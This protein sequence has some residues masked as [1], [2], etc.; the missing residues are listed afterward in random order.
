MTLPNAPD[1]VLTLTLSLAVQAM[2]FVFAASA[3]ALMLA[4][5][6]IVWGVRLA[7]YLLFRISG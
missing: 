6:A 1:L 2:F 4:A 5:M 7:G 3:P